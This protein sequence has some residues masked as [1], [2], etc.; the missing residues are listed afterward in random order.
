MDKSDRDKPVDLLPDRAVQFINLVAR[1]FRYRKKVRQEVLDELVT[2]FEDE[3]RGCTSE[4]DRDQK[5]QQLIAEFGDPGLLAVLMR[6]AK[7]RC[8]PLWAKVL[9]HS[10]Q[11][12]GILL[13]Y[14]VICAL[15]LRIGR[16]T[17]RVNYLDWI[18]DLVRDNKDESLNAKPYLDKAVQL[19]SKAPAL[20]KEIDQQ[21]HRVLWPED[22][23]E[24]QQKNIAEFLGKNTEALDALREAVEKPH[25]WVHYELDRESPAARAVL[26][27]GSFSAGL[28]EQAN[29][30]LPGY[31][32]LAFRMVLQI[33]CETSQ[34]DVE[35]AFDDCLV[36]TKFGMHLQG[37]GFLIEKLV[38]LSIE[39]LA[40][41]QAFRVLNTADMPAEV[42]KKAQQRLETLYS[43]QKALIIFDA[44]KALLYEYVQR[45]FTDDGKGNGR[46]LKDGIPLVAVDIKSTLTGFLLVRFPD[47]QEVTRRIDRFYE[48]LDRLLVIPPSSAAFQGQAERLKQI[49]LGNIFLKLEAPA[50]ERVGQ[51]IW[52][53]KTDRQA[54][55]TVLGVMRCRKEK[56]DCPSDLNEVV[57]A[58]Y[59]DK[60]PIDPYSGRP[61]VYR[62]T[63][64][65]F[66]LY[67]LG[68]DLKDDGG[69]L[70][71]DSQGRPRMW[72]E[73]GDW[74]FWPV[75]DRP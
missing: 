43:A 54:L 32:D 11:A 75:A 4:Q 60:L 15:P 68:T 57:A 29:R 45:S 16:P 69:R 34:G 27:P 7:K 74:V 14:L 58:G 6:R 50:F 44:E 46:V 53:L 48:E 24:P 5:A 20:P 72:A 59:L 42:L 64:G 41:K 62:R 3:L 23:N 18:N 1:K 71:T 70:G 35:G 37:K 67:S 31:R 38:G 8:R 40:N 30:T 9:I 73:N 22:M 55:T 65:G 47:R 33:A 19:A 36:L 51:Q 39:A 52:R 49:A 13:L 56:G 17:I 28:V 26:G 12:I 66:L 63:D 2:H 61:L 25:Y 21:G 10:F